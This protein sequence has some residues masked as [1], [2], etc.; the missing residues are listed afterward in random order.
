MAAEHEDGRAEA[1]EASKCVRAEA[2]GVPKCMQAEA[3]EREDG[4]AEAVKASVRDTGSTEAEAASAAKRGGLMRSRRTV[5][6]LALGALSLALVVVSAAFLLAPPD[7]PGADNAGVPQAVQPLE[8]S[9]SQ[10]AAGGEGALGGERSDRADQADDVDESGDGAGSAA[11]A[12]GARDSSD[13]DTAAS[14]ERASRADGDAESAQG[15]S[16]AEDP[17]SFSGSSA[18]S[19]V[20]GGDKGAAGGNSS[21]SRSGNSSGDSGGSGSSGASGSS[22][23]GSSQGAS[24]EQPSRADVVRITVSVDSSAVGNP[25]S[26]GTTAT[27]ERGA[28]AYDALMAC[29][30]SVDASQSQYGVYVSA[31]GGLAEKQHGGGSGWTYLVNGNAIMTSCSSYTLQDGDRIQWTYIV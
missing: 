8:T 31:I 9:G 26:G 16:A 1:A 6:G 4:R 3:A 17:A 27:F 19:Q 14:G 23:S 12:S 18:G 15:A 30:L 13:S 25:V 2:V 22:S 5:A 29:G 28:T 20:S 21:G 7:A 11:S 10:G 24:S